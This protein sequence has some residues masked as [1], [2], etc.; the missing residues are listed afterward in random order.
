MTTRL[1]F[2]GDFLSCKSSPRPAKGI[3]QKTKT[4]MK[5]LFT[6]PLKVPSSSGFVGA[7]GEGDPCD[8]RFKRGQ[9]ECHSAK[10]S[11]RSDKCPIIVPLS[12][13]EHTVCGTGHP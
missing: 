8:I 9:I 2:G 13:G 7:H 12:F 3:K 6:N 5:A 1:S 11:P 4:K 10:R